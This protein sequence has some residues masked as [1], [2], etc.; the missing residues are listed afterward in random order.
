MNC[1]A[2]GCENPGDSAFCEGCGAKLDAACPSCGAPVSPGA[3]FCRKCGAPTSMATAKGTAAIRSPRDYTPKHLAD[4]ILQSKSALEGE[5]K[6]VTVMFADVKGSMEL[7]EQLD[8]EE[9]HAILDRFFAILTDG[10]HRF[11]GT[12][13]QYTGD[14]IMALF[15]APIAHEDHAQRAC[16]AALHLRDTVREYANAVRLR[17]GV[18]FGVRIGINS[19]AV[20]VGKIGD[21][22]R[23]DYTAQGHTVGLAQRMEALA[24]SGHICLSEHTARLVEGYFQLH[25]LG[26]TKVKGVSDLVGLFDLEGVGAFRTR[27]DRSRARGLSRFVGRDADT[28]I[29]EAALQRAKTSS[30]QVVGI[31]ADAGTGKSRLCAEFLDTCRARGIPVFEGCGVAHGKSIPMLPMLELWRAFYGITERDDPETVRAKIAGRLLLM[32]DA[33]RDVLPFL[34][35]LFGV[36]DP[37]NPA[38]AIDPEQRQKRIHGVIKR[39]LHDPTFTGQTRVFL[40][41]DLHWFDGASDA[42]LETTIESAPAARDLWIVNFRPEYQARW[43]QRSYY[44]HLALQPLGPDAIRAL[45]RDHLGDDPSVAALPESIHARTKGN[46]FFIEEVVQSLVENGHLTG[47]RGAYK[48]TT[49]IAALEVPPTVQAVLAARIDRLPER[50][51]QVLQ[52]AA[53]IGKTFAESLLRQVV[54]SVSKLDETALS[55]SLSALAAAEFLFEAALYPHLEYSFKHP[56]TQE[57]ALGSQLRERRAKVHAAV[58]QALEEAG[59]NLDERAAEIAQHWAE[60]GEAARAARW[61]RRAAEW[62][63]MSNLT[64]G[65]NHWRRVRELA[66]SVENERERIDMSLQACDQILNLA[67]R[68]GGTEEEAAAVFEEGRALAE[69][70][71]DRQALA[72]FIGRYGLIRASVAGRADEYIRYGTEAARIAENFDDPGLR[73]AIRT[74]P[75]YAYFM[76]GSGNEGLEWSERALADVGTD[77]L[78][79]KVFIGYSPRVSMHHVRASASMFLGQLD[80]S[81]IRFDEAE[82]IAAEAGDLEVD[83]WIQ[84]TRMM[85]AHACGAG[86]STTDRGRRTLEVAEKLDNE[87]SRSIAYAVLGYEY[88]L[89]QQLLAAR[90]AL[91]NSA[92]ISKSQSTVRHLLPLGLAMLSEAHHALGERAEALATAREAINFASAGRLHYYEAWAQLALTAALLATDG[93]IPRADIESALARAEHLVKSIA[94]RALS[95]QI[96]E[97]RGRLAAALGDATTSGRLL[98]EAFD[99]YRSIGARGHAARLEKELAS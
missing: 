5:R 75:A 60:A 31:V 87:G 10:V 6:Q 43:M 4:K 83:G 59:G 81:R 57:V 29:L 55:Q 91:L 3:K 24:E 32:D 62:A 34:F 76:T 15:G 35:D 21:D 71:G 53:I 14:G 93:A 37:A 92:R 17:H 67:W 68:T 99:L 7:A 88:L 45:L 1:T 77:N 80:D 89:G 69:R 30:G 74:W 25:D 50:E 26:R 79:G 22:L 85:L 2:C 16:Y 9:W 39:V 84:F 95:P 40:L 54:T 58:A 90:E 23:M 49:P 42:F 28:A 51:K 27:L 86:D 94:A 41:E 64:E 33:Y 56:L 96:L 19:G 47:A 13:N 97:K 73:A 8:P 65:L 38:P 78:L 70:K 61:Y 72:L 82:R 12:V 11:E 52:T 36:P 63:G 98:R 66:P 18:P 20:V 46:P 48:L 44:Q